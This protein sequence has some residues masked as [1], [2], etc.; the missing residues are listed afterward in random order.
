MVATQIS[1]WP[2]VIFFRS[3][4]GGATWTRI[5]DFTQL[6]EPQLPLHAWTS[7]PRRG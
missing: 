6:P 4:D 5:W 1:W 7:P 3:T 2:D